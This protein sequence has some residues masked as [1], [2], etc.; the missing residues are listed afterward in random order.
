MAVPLACGLIALAVA[1]AGVLQ[2]VESKG[3]NITALVGIIGGEALAPAVM[4]HDADFAFSADHLD[5]AYFYAIAVDPLARGA[6]HDLVDVPAYRFGHPGYGWLAWLLAGGRSSAVP[7]TLL[8]IGLVSMFFAG[9]A[10]SVLARELG[11]TPWAGLVVALN[12]GLIFA[13]IADNSEPLAVAVLAL[14]LIAWLRGRVVLAGACFLALCLIK[15]QFVLVPMGIL[16]WELM[17]VARARVDPPT[18]REWVRRVAVL[19][20]GPLALGVWFTYLRSVFEAWP[21]QQ[22]PLLMNPLTVPPLGYLD[23]LGKAADMHASAGETAQLGGVALP[24]LLV[25]GVALLI[26]IIR[27]LRFTSP[28]DA[29]FVLLTFLMFS[30]TWVQ[31]LFPKDLLRIAA[32]QL[33]LLPAAIAGMRAAPGSAVDGPTAAV[34]AGEAS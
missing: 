9:L 25:V 12:P 16:L 32:V 22:Y 20:A 13:T 28:V 29:V 34:P 26:G 27:A 30:L 31:L 3:G 11:W 10:A 23:T 17:Q 14:S 7:N 8:I 33:A 18:A 1:G 19:A 5:G 15:E 24:L 2:A 6:E 4:Q 21:F